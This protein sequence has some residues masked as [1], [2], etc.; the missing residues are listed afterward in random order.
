MSPVLVFMTG[1]W[2]YDES[3]LV[4][5]ILSPPPQS[6]HISLLVCHDLPQWEF[7]LL[8][9]F[10]STN[11]VFNYQY[12]SKLPTILGN[13]S[14]TAFTFL[15]LL[16]YG[17]NHLHVIHLSTTVRLLSGSTNVITHCISPLGPISQDVLHFL[18]VYGHGDIA[19]LDWGD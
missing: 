19:I 2:V 12:N 18:A 17:V 11:N 5:T 7:Y 13:I 16:K 14:C 4:S 6:F 1:I 9:T 3:V 10:I 15:L 8:Y